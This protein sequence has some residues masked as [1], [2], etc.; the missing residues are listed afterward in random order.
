MM[1]LFHNNDGKM[2]VCAILIHSSGLMLARA[3]TQHTHK[4]NV[5]RHI[6]I[7]F[8]VPNITLILYAKH[9]FD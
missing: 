1:H 6:K 3:H 7:M 2:R 9:N 4:H 5:G 8:G